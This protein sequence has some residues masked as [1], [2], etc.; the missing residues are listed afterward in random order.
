MH[1]RAWTDRAGVK[2]WIAV[3]SVPLDRGGQ[4]VA[5]DS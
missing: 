5:V 3:V 2:L 1:L 4:E